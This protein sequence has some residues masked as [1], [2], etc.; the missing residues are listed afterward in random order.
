MSIYIGRQKVCVCLSV[1]LSFC[2][3]VTQ[4]QNKKCCSYYALAVSRA[5][6]N[7]AV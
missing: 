4:E 7:T 2:Q 6:K 1:A 5:L 3:S